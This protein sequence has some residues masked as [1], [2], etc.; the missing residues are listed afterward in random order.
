[1]SS[2]AT[3]TKAFFPTSIDPRRFWLAGL[4]AFALAER[5]GRDLLRQL[6]AEG[7]RFRSEHELGAT[8]IAARLSE[9]LAAQRTAIA[10]WLSEV[11][12]QLARASEDIASSLIERLGIP[13]RRELR[14]LSAR[15]AEL[16]RRLSE[17]AN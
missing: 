4:G 16:Q 11:S 2:T 9:R 5:H 7:Q 14:E 12:Q 17:L 10:R 1:M 3:A 15:I 6:I 13:S 8:A